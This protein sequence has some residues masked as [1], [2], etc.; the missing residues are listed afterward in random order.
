LL[1]RAIRS[2]DIVVPDGIGIIIASM[3]LGEK[4]RERTT[5]WISFSVSALY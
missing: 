3:I 5:V 4:I 2:A 1:Q